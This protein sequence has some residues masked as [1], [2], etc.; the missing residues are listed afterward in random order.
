MSKKYG[1]KKTTLMIVERKLLK[2]KLLDC[3][4]KIIY[5]VQGVAKN[6]QTLEYL[7]VNIDQGI[8]KTDPSVKIL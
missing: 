3:L 1:L 2:E 6:P 8:L 5:Y 4:S 7:E